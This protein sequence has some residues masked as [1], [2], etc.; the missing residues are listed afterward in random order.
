MT[1]TSPWSFG[2]RTM[3]I[4]VALS[5]IPLGWTTYMLHWVQERQAF[6]DSN[7][8]VDVSAGWRSKAPLR[9][10][11]ML[12]FFGDRRLYSNMYIDPEDLSTASRL[13]PETNL[14]TGKGKDRLLKSGEWL[15]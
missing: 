9:Y 4:L 11:L 8:G 12:W 6:M 15:K 14:Y 10:S 5:A 1:D 2:L 3:L 13:F 7:R